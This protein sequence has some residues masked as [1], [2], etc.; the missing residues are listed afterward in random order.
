MTTTKI[1]KV[2]FALILAFT[3]F[4]PFSSHSQVEAA[5]TK[6][7]YVDVTSGSLTVRNGAGTKYKKVGTL[8]DNVKVTVYSQTKSGWSEIKY[9]KKKAYVSTQ[10]L[11]FDSKM[12]LSTAKAI[13]DKVIALQRKT[14][15]RNYTKKQIYSIMT[16]G[17]TTSFIDH[18]FKQ[19]MRTAGQD[20]YG[21]P[22]YHQIETEVWGYNIDQFD[23]NLDYSSKKP[24]VKS[25]YKNGKQYLVV[26]QY[27]RNE[28]TGNFWNY[29]YLSKDHSKSSWKVYKNSR[30][31]D[32]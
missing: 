20:R 21:N 28:M 1:V 13:T 8:K 7:A 4:V 23:W 11:R 5:S 22:L 3:L 12:S 27:L 14:W 17:Y 24:I 2:I 25:Y 19:Q 6:T 29:L 18:F 31:Y 15:E 9:N 16:P 10:Y 30:K 26:S 32:N